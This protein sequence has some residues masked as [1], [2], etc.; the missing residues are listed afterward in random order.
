MPEVDP[1]AG[2]S[3]AAAV[4]S[5]TAQIV[6]ALERAGEA[7]LLA[8]SALPGWTRLTIAC[9]LRYGARASAD[10]TRRAL[11]GQ[12][13]AFY[14]GGRAARRPRTLV[15]DEG[16]APYDVVGSLATEGAALDALW[17]GLTAGQW[18]RPVREPDDNLRLGA[19]NVA[20]TALLRLTEVEAHGED[21]DLG[22]PDWSD[23]FVRHALPARLAWLA[24]RRSNHRPYDR[25]V[26]GS[27][28]FAADDTG[29]RWL[30]AVDGDTVT[31]R[32]ADTAETADAVI[33]GSARALL[34]LLLGRTEPASLRHDGDQRLA[35]AFN[36]AFPGP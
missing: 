6:E 34:A 23:V 4:R 8:P 19:A 1:S 11:A 32:P 3:I 5:R 33:A 21:L 7:G 17:A 27:W 20:M 26:R 14:P 30:V 31:S 24:T 25:Q 13:A 16:E 18:A 2:P 15:P 12:P 36:A 10:V 35:G 29:L 28:L 9:H 22:L